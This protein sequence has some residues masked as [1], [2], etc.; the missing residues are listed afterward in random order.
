MMILEKGEMCPY[1][2][3]CPHNNNNLSM[4]CFGANPNRDNKFTCEFV[5]NGQILN[6]GNT[7]LPGDKTGK[8]KIIME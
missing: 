2:S 3:Q 8:M 7:R 4:S 6:N 1:S 5:V